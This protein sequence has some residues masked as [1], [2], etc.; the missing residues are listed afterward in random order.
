VTTTVVRPKRRA[1]SGK[2]PTGWLARLGAWAGSHLRV[3][4]LSWLIVLAAFG[5]FA[6]RV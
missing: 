6:P 5:A 1:E 4:L 3:V 2:T